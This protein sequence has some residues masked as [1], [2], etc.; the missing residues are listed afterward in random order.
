MCW[1]ALIF[2]LPFLRRSGG[3]L[4]V[5]VYDGRDGVQ[6]CIL[7]GWHPRHEERAIL[8]GRGILLAVL[9]ALYTR[10]RTARTSNHHTPQPEAEPTAKPDWRLTASSPVTRRSI[11]PPI[12]P[13]G[14][15][16]L[17]TT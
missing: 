9:H 7:P 11:R 12:L 15:G 3:V 2:T 5:L 1:Q 14:G 17:V 13:P 8:S 10:R 16:G 4:V 6:S